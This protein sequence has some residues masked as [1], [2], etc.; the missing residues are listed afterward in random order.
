[1]AR[2]AYDPIAPQSRA[3]PAA[4]PIVDLN[5]LLGRLQQ[6]ILRADADREQRLRTSVYEREKARF[7][8]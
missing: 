8:S 5:R 4:D 6:T 2:V 3:K 7:V 1:M